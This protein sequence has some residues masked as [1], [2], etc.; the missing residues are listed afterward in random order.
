MSPCQIF[1]ALVASLSPLAVYG[2]GR[3]K[4]LLLKSIVNL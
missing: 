4:K 2:Q 1:I 3:L